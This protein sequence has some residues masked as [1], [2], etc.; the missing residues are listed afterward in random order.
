MRQSC[1]LPTPAGPTSSVTPPHGTPPR[2]AASN[3][4]T[5]TLV[6]DEAFWVEV[7][8]TLL[9]GALH[10]APGKLVSVVALATPPCSWKWTNQVRN[11]VA[12]AQPNMRQS[13]SD[14][15]HDKGKMQGG[16][17]QTVTA[18]RAC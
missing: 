12:G 8:T 13:L 17:L 5:T 15:R 7:A 16:V 1:D 3:A 2:S 4:C 6:L 10:A 14:M 18:Y 9:A 11:K